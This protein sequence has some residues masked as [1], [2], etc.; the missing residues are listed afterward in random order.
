M[1][2]LQACVDENWGCYSSSCVIINEAALCSLWP[3]DCLHTVCCCWQS[4]EGHSWFSI[5]GCHIDLLCLFEGSP[6]MSAVWSGACDTFMD[7]RNRLGYQP[8][9]NLLANRKPC[10][11]YPG[12]GTL[13]HLETTS[14]PHWHQVQ[15][16]H[17]GIITERQPD[18]TAY[19]TQVSFQ[20]VAGMCYHYHSV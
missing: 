1:G 2:I 9:T 12:S 5:T 3:T 13:C 8:I 19:T 17:L 10:L 16:H 20:F 14:L 6:L 11:H 4:E 15:L 7:A 18:E